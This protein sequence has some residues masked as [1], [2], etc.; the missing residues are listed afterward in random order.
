MD[1]S[2]QDPH[3]AP[4]VEA[5]DPERDIDAKKT[6]FWL[7]GTLVIV[8][9]S[10]LALAQAFHISVRGQQQAVIEELPPKEL[11]Q[12]RSDEDYTLKKLSPAGA[13]DER[14]LDEINASIRTTTDAIIADYLK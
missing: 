4:Q 12:L 9:I 7:A 6:F 10:L 5:I 14:S 8:V 3:G 1:T 13:A 2:T 11:R